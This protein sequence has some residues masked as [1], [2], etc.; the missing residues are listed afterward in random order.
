LTNKEGPPLLTENAEVDG[1][2]DSTQK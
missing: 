1:W 2:K